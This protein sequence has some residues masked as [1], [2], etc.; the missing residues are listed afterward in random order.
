[1]SEEKEIPILLTLLFLSIFV[2][3]GTLYM[4]IDRFFLPQVSF[5][6]EVS[7]DKIEQ[8][9]AENSDS[10]VELRRIYYIEENGKKRFIDVNDTLEQALREIDKSMVTVT[11]KTEGSPFR[12]TLR[13]IEN[14]SDYRPSDH[15]VAF[16][17]IALGR[18]DLMDFK[19]R[20]PEL[21]I[22]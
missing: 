10:P 1:M 13:R 15:I 9:F 14:K 6:T 21:K 18:Q 19:S 8:I 3:A 12:K 7:G 17:I 22:E 20:H 2:V 16:D 5:E 4:F 11:I